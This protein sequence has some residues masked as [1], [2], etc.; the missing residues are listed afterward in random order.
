MAE[1]EKKLAIDLTKKQMLRAWRLY[2]QI[3]GIRKKM[4]TDEPYFSLK[5]A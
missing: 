2:R 4:T 3:C 5:P 1:E